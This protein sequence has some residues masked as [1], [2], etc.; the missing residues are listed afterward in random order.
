M[1]LSIIMTKIE[2]EMMLKVYI[3]DLPYSSEE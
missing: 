2:L 1:V 3:C